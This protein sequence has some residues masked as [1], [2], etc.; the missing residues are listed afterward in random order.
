MA[1]ATIVSG[2]GAALQNAINAAV[3]GDELDVQPGTYTPVTCGKGI[4]ITLRSG[5]EVGALFSTTVALLIAGVPATQT[6][7]LAGGRVF[8]ISVT[9]SSGTVVIDQT[10]VEFATKLRSTGSHATR[11]PVCRML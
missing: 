10:A 8:G 7:V 5:A 9:Q 4:R 3:A 2:G 11:A 6:C 1:Q